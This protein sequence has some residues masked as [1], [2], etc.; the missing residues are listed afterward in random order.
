MG[1]P[2]TNLSIKGDS[3]II[4]GERFKYGVGTHAYSRM[5]IDLDGMADMFSA[6]VGLDDGAYKSASIS[7]FVLGDKKI[8][9]ESGPMNK[10]DKA[11]KVQV[12]L[13]GLK[14]LGLLVMVNR[15]NISENYADWANARIEFS[16]Q[17][18]IAN[19]NSVN[20]VQFDILTPPSPMKPVINGP[21]VYGVRPGSPFLYRIPTTGK[22]PMSFS[23]KYLPAGLILDKK[24]GIITGTIRQAGN[25]KIELV[26]KN[27]SGSSK[28]SFT[29]IAG[30]KLALTPPMGWNSWYIYYNMVSDSLMRLAADLMISSGMANYGYEYVNIDDCWM[31]KPGKGSADEN[32]PARSSAGFILCNKRFP[33]MKSMTEYI[34]SKGLKAGIYSSPGPITCAGYT[35]S[36]QFEKKDVETFADWEFDFLKY[37]WCSYGSVAKGN[38]LEDLKAPFKLISDEL[39]K[40]NRDILLNL[41]Q[42]GMGDVWKWGQEVGQSWRTTGDLGVS[43][44]SFL[45][46]FYNTGLS[47]AQHWQYAQPGAWNDPDYIMLGWVGTYGGSAKGRKVALTPNEQYSYM[48]MWSMMAAPLFFSGDMGKLDPFIL[49]VLCNNEVIAINQDP[50]GRQGRIIRNDEKGMIMLKELSDSSRAIALF[51]F[52]GSKKNPIDYFIWDDFGN[53][54]KIVKFTANEVGI[55]GKFRVRNVWTQKEMGVFEKEFETI[56][57]YHGVMLLKIILLNH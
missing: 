24:T 36:Y 23:A 22:Q 4:D 46:G 13:R 19:N 21:L 3:L 26:A 10:G 34:H 5:L 27:S 53:G 48:T 6:S 56:V 41:C 35:G 42:Y 20:A 38:K 52:P 14:K 55:T 8:L 45:P 33:G 51:N 18:P 40:V 44:G 49:N 30:N 39:Q 15:E 2:R 31:N 1:V 7:F 17:A 47:N 28:R 37:D 29:I 11:K 16:G 54:S 9:W 50:L 43:T 25:Y 32:G 57:P 12:N